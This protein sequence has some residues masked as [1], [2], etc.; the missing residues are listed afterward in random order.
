[1]VLPSFWTILLAQGVENL[2]I[3]ALSG[4]YLR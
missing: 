3:A 1:M 4:T 2:P